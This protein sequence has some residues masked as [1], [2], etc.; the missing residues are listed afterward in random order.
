MFYKDKR[1]ECRKECDR[2][3][4]R[5]NPALR[6]RDRD[7]K[8]KSQEISFKKLLEELK[9]N[10][11]I[12]SRYYDRIDSC[13]LTSLPSLYACGARGGTFPKGALI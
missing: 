7:V 9:T 6:D 8:Y 12:A 13:S 3:L 1:D 2:C 5:F 4:R 11:R 10:D